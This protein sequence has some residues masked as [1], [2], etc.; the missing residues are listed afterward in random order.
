[1]VISSPSLSK[2][3]IEPVAVDF[4]V[5]PVDPATEFIALTASSGWELDIVKFPELTPLIL[6]A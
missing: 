3:R 1:M 6:M 2:S 5:T 4:A